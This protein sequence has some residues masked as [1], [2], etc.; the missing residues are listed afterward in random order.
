MTDGLRE[1][2]ERGQHVEAVAGEDGVGVHPG[3]LAPWPDGAQDRFS[4][5]GITAAA[6]LALFG[7]AEAVHHH[8]SIPV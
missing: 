2:G 7:L 3:S 1:G 6:A 8:T 4:A 5:P